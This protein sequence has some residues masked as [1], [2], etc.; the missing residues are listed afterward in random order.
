MYRELT[1]I[2]NN[3]CGME[4]PFP[5]L[6]HHGA[7]NLHFQQ[8][9]ISSVHCFIWVAVTGN[10]LRDLYG[11][12]I[13]AMEGSWADQHW[14][15]VEVVCSVLLFSLSTRWLHKH[16]SDH[17]HYFNVN[18]RFQPVNC[19]GLSASIYHVQFQIGMIA[20]ACRCSYKTSTFFAH[21]HVSH[22]TS[23]MISI[24]SALLIFLPVLN[25]TRAAVRSLS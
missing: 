25:T 16:A 8:S 6:H 18:I 17:Y 22:S 24:N 3:T 19:K 12:S 10:E 15:A 11:A 1:P 20:D 5:L 14:P 13:P 23:M 9:W 2:Y 4:Q 21:L 7:P